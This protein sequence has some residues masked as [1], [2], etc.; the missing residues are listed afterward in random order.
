[1][2]RYDRLLELSTFSKEKLQLLHS[3]NILIIGVGGVGQYVSTSLITNGIIKMSIVDFD[4]VELS[5]LNRQILLTEDDIGKKKVDVVKS[6]L[7]SKN[8][9]ASIKSIELR[10]D[11]SNIDDLISDYDVIIDAT[12]NWPTKLMISKACHKQNK[13]HLHVGVDGN[14]GQYCLFKNK[15]L[16]DIVSEDI[17][18][19]KRDGV[20]GPMVGLISSFAALLL[21]RHLCGD[22]V[23]IDVIYSYDLL[24]NRIV[25]LKL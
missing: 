25:E 21:I 11:E 7:L 16:L 17:V 2:S 13:L 4:V 1:M 9:D 10:V 3:K 22:N 23:E 8:S 15:Y 19:E 5:N 18:K 14:Q 24:T 12:D 20:M 6:A